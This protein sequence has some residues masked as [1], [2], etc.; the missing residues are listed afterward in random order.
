[1]EREQC[2]KDASEVYTSDDFEEREQHLEEQDAVIWKVVPEPSGLASF[3]EDLEEEID[4]T[5]LKE[6][7]PKA[8]HAYLNIFSERQSQRLPEHSLWDHAIDLKPTFK[9]QALK[10]YALSPEKHDK[11]GKFIK[12]HLA[13][14]TIRRSTSHSTTPFFFVGKKDGKLRPVQDYRHLNEH[15]V[16]NVCPLPLIQELLDVIKGVIKFTK[17][18]VWWGYNNICI[19]EGDEWKASFIIPLGL[20]E[21]T[22]MFFG[23]TNS[24]A[25]FQAMMNMIFQD[26]IIARK[27]TVY[28]DNILIFSKTMAEHVQI[29]NQ[30]LQI[31]HDNDLYLKPKKCEFYKDELNY[32]GFTISKDHVAMEDS[33][34]DAIRDWPIPHTIRDI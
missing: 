7:V 16:C 6:H 28:M 19:K 23:L 13:R 34:V 22:V 31:L 30:V 33:K 10:I 20:F 14:G 17:L 5:N 27:I 21:P 15:T 2:H 9:P 1:M 4:M 12:E 24:P 26:L 8:H 18:E 32:L 11:L 25:T 29:I 3:D